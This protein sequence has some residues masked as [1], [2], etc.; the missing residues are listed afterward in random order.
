MFIDMVDAYNTLQGLNL[1]L[2]IKTVD[3]FVFYSFKQF[4]NF[5]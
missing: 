2:Y 1:K 3:R 5:E 4:I